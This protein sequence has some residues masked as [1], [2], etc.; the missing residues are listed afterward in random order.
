MGVANAKKYS[1]YIGNKNKI[2]KVKKQKVESRKLE[3]KIKSRSTTGK[4]KNKNTKQ[5]QPQTIK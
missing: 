3:Q 1:L 5:K 2:R 4:V